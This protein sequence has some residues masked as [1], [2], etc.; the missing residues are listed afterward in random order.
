MSMAQVIRAAMKKQGVTVSQLS[1]QL[2]CTTQNISGKMRRDNFRESELQE[3]AAAIGCR[4][5]GRFI[6]EETGKPV[7]SADMRFERIASTSGVRTQRK[8]ERFSLAPELLL[9]LL[10]KPQTPFMSE[11]K[12]LPELFRNLLLLFALTIIIIL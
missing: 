6:S 2:G 8:K 3:I 12:I 11:L 5:E 7:E 9:L 1:R 10:G 4:F